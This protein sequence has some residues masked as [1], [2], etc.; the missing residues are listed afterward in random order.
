M[1]CVCG[2]WRPCGTACSPST[3]YSSLLWHD[4]L[5]HCYFI[6]TWALCGDP[7]PGSH[8]SYQTVKVFPLACSSRLCTERRPT[9]WPVSP[10]NICTYFVILSLFQ[11]LVTSV[12]CDSRWIAWIWYFGIWYDCIFGK[13][14]VWRWKPQS[15][16]I[17]MCDCPLPCFLAQKG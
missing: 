8:G 15:Q 12:G 5:M 4:I 14:I 6:N 3:I 16:M 10:Q 1:G 17:W 2:L 13:Y 11:R 9:I 7:F